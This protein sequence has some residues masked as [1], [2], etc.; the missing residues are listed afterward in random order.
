MQPSLL[1]QPP[2]NIHEDDREELAVLRRRLASP[3]KYAGEIL[4]GVLVDR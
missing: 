3:A 4:W 1:Y 2:Q